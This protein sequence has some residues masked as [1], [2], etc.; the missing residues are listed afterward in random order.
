MATSAS[1][2]VV[3][4][5]TRALLSII[6]PVYNEVATVA[7]VLE[8]LGQID[9]PLDREIIVVD[10]G[11]TDGTSEL[12]ATLDAQSPW[13]RVFRNERNLGKGAAVRLGMSRARGAILAIQDAD[14]ELDPQQLNG[15]VAPI[16]AGETD[17]VFGSRF[18]NGR[19]PMPRISYYANRALT[20]ITNALYGSRLTDMETC[21]KV[22]R[23]DVARSLTLSAN[24]FDI[25]PE[26]TAK[27]LRKGYRVVERPVRF[28]PRSRAHGKKIGWRDA[29]QAVGVLC[30]CRF[31]RS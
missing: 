23:A 22:M 16:L 2:V 31:A 26:V 27:I 5:N 3:R 13:L 6:V 28:T 15:L 12:L 4:A 21:Y 29:V 11:S 19:P 25:E 7:R 20:G 24:R 1:P 18:L 14:L 10:D 30:R 17:V 8:R 9:L